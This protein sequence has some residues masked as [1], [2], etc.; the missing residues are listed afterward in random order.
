MAT[1]YTD[2]AINQQQY[3]NFFGESGV[4]TL[5]TQPGTQN[6]PLLE[7]PPTIS[8]TYLWTG[9]EAANDIINIAILPAGVI[10]SPD[11]HVA[12]GLTAISSTL[13]LAIGDNDL[14]APSSLPIP[15]PTAVVSQQ[16]LGAGGNPGAWTAPAWVSGTNY[17][18]G[19]VVTDANA[20]PANTVYTAV[21]NITNSTTAPHSA[22]NTVWMPNYQ[23][24]SNSI[25]CHAAS[26]NVAFSGGTQLYGGAFSLLPYSVVPNSV[27]QNVTNSQLLNQQYQ[28]QQ[29]CWLQAQILTINTTTLNANA[30]SVFRVGITASN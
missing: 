20:T 16:S 12:S 23:R 6:R 2:V 26:G 9:N 10:V 1:W 8:A 28:I 17:A 18:A 5:T 19:N 25:D 29:D 24:Y 15:N 27:P 4:G 22:A 7:G 13:T 3:V 21:A 14:G 30:V 11:G